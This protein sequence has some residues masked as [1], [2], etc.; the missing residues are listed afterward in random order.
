MPGAV[1]LQAVF[2]V[3]LALGL[4]GPS[5]PMWKPVLKWRLLSFRRVVTK[6]HY[7]DA[8]LRWFS[9]AVSFW[10]FEALFFKNLVIQG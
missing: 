7:W 8:F 5:T 4:G 2:G 6:I 3:C 9:I 1:L 10:G